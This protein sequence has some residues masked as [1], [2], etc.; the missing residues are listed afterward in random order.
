M[1]RLYVLQVLTGKEIEIRDHLIGLGMTAYVPRETVM[2]HCGGIWSE[3]ERI[4][5]SSYVF[6][7][8][9]FSGEKYYSLRKI[10]GVLRLLELQNGEAAALTG[11]EAK[12]ILLMCPTE[13][14][15]PLSTVEIVDGNP[16]TVSGI[17]KEYADKGM[18]IKYDKHRRRATLFIPF[19][20]EWKKISLSFKI[21]K[22]LNPAA[23]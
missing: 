21:L 20:G 2:L 11:I 8:L 6:V 23:G 10:D 16:V 22:N 13:N 5:F 19:M 4:V 18:S 17:L 14:P 9:C 12:N 15:L 1:N 3:E 7:E